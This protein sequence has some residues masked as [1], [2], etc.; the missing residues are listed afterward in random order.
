M[1][2]HLDHNRPPPIADQRPHTFKHHGITVSDPWHWLKDDGYPKV[3][4]PDVL[5]YLKAE[6]SHYEESMADHAALTE[7]IFGEIRGRMKEDDAAVPWRLGDFDYAWH[8]NT[9]DEYRTWTRSSTDGEPQVILD[10]PGEAKGHEYFRVGDV[11]ISPDSKLMAWSTDTSGAERYIIHVKSLVTGE[12]LSDTVAETSGDITWTTDSSGFFY[13]QVNEEWRPHKVFYHILGESGDRLVYEE[14]D[15]SFFVH[16]GATQSRDWLTIAT[17]DHV[18][19]E[20]RLV[21]LGTPDALPVLVAER[22]VGHE[23]FVEHGNGQFVIRTNDTHKNFRIVVTPEENPTEEAWR[24]LLTGSQEHYY[25]SVT[26]FRDFIAIAERVNGLDQIQIRDWEGNQHFID[27]PESVYATHLGTNPEFDQTHLRLGYTSMITPASIFDYDISARRLDLRKEQE[28]PSGY[29]KSAYR[30]ERLMAKA[31]DGVSVPVTLVY[32][33]DFNAPG[34]LHLYGYG[35]YGAGT[36]PAFSAS[37][38]SLLDRGF[39]YAIAHVRGG[40][41]MGYHWYEDGKLAK[42]TNTFNDFVDVARFLVAEG[43]ATE[44]NISAS[45]GSAGGELMGA[46]IVQA[47]ELWKA[48]VLH[49]PFVDVLNTMLDESLPLT[50]IEWP[51]WGNPID[52]EEAFR[53]IQSYSP[54]DNIEA[55]DYPMQMVTGGL[56]DPRVTYWEPAKWTARMR[57]TKTDNNLLVM[58]INM[59]AGHGGKT[60]RFQAVQ[61]VSEEYTF[62]L[63]AFGMAN[64]D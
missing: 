46:V 62:L 45:G 24:E 1:T 53:H 49:V 43:Y 31:R 8:F 17:G 36:S 2:T 44:G 52:S 28:L 35:A 60:G 16:I 48:V 20:V 51:E 27:F 40:D 3:T 58:K 50:P 4:D 21:P 56:N 5:A 59:G 47:P 23:Y 15:S 37:R 9:G 13:V 22:R 41:E 54:Y 19:S 29:D 57:A 42:R 61:E 12:L 25:R 30:T 10:E 11:S 34:P 64:D 55:R 26:P 18:T 6:N 32:R 33:T 14:P 63:K 7:T 39:A 38:L